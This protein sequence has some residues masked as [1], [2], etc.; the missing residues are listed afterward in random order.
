MRKYSK[1]PRYERIVVDTVTISNFAKVGKLDPVCEL[2]RGNLYVTEVVVIELGKGDIDITDWISDGRIKKAEFSYDA[3]IW[4]D[5]SGSL[6]DGEI[7]CIVYAVESN[8]A[9]ATDDGAARKAVTNTY[10]HAKLSGTVGLLA[11][12]VQEGLIT[13]QYARELLE[14]MIDKGFWYKG[15]IPFG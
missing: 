11:E 1:L 12:L 7:S 14:E 5:I 4:N 6:A 10:R 9:I 3:E 15:D 13:G 2:Y 8:C